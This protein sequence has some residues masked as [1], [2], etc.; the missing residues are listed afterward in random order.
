MCSQA[1]PLHP[2]WQRK[3][4][5]RLPWEVGLLYLG[6]RVDVGVMPVL[7]ILIGRRFIPRCVRQGVCPRSAALA[8]HLGFAGDVRS[9]PCIKT[10][11]ATGC[12]PSAEHLFPTKPC[13]R[14]P[15]PKTG[16]NYPSGCYLTADL[17]AGVDGFGF[18]LVEN[19]PE[20]SCPPESP[21]SL[22]FGDWF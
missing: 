4:D 13:A 11:Q 20:G 9:Y 19:F 21:S 16:W 22:F 10:Y 3:A 18:G 8:K 17:C 12:Q 15:I 6:K 1:A 14:G 7:S 5:C 2:A